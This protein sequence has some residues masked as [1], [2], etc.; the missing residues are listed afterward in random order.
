[1]S[2][3][4]I[5]P[6]VVALTIT[7]GRSGSS[8]LYHSLRATAHHDEAVYHELLHPMV[9]K[10]AVFHRCF[11]EDRKKQLRSELAVGRLLEEW[12][13]RIRRG[14]IIDI[15]WTMSSLAPLMADEFGNSF[16][17]LVLHRHPVEFAASAYIAGRY[18]EKRHEDFSLSPFH[19]GAYFRD[20]AERWAHMSCFEKCLFWWLET[21]HYGQEMAA[22]L[23]VSQSKFVSLDELTSRPSMLEEIAQFF[24]IRAFNAVRSSDITNRRMGKNLE[25]RPLGDAWRSYVEHDEVITLASELGYDMSEGYVRQIAKRYQR[26]KGMG[27]WL[28]STLRYWQLRTM[29]SEALRGGG[30]MPPRKSAA[31]IRRQAAGFIDDGK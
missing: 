15:G 17:M 10:P 2:A 1:M 8:F 13:C 21:F 6:Y 30:V 20:Y 16:R 5:S 31:R 22:R 29:V 26:P 28:R 11:D 7:T 19:E 12:K 25:I 24:G 14:S 23:N 9:A 18:S 4:H 3:A 27:P